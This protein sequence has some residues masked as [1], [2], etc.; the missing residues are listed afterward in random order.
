VNKTAI[1]VEVVP[2]D[3]SDSSMLN[4]TYE[5]TEFGE[6]GMTVQLNFTNAIEVS[7]NATDYIKVTFWGW[8]NFT[9]TEGLTFAPEE[10]R[11]KEMPT[12]IPLGPHVDWISGLGVVTQISV[13]VVISASLM[14]S[15]CYDSS[16]NYV[17]GLLEN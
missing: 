2:G 1:Q 3:I 16:I 15:Y 12:Q 7:S 8:W 6:Q 13:T 10:V 14:M 5:V 4:F 9:D 17:L 11:I